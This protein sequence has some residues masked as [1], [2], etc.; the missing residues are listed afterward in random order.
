MLLAP[1]SDNPPHGELDFKSVKDWLQARRQMGQ[2]ADIRT[3]VLKANE[4]LFIPSDWWHASINYG[5]TLA[6]ASQPVVA[7]QKMRMLTDAFDQLVGAQQLQDA[8]KVA[9]S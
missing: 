3:C 9:F 4:S 5:A 7:L 8:V 1:P 6:V 2:L